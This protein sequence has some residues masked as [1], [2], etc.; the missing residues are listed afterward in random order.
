M[1]Q[2]GFPGNR[3]VILGGNQSD[4]VTLTK[5]SVSDLLSITRPPGKRP[6][7]YDATGVAVS[8]GGSTS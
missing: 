6:E 8:T 4:K 3:V 2:T 1:A 7:T 5:K